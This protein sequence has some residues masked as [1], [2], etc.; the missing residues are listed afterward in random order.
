MFAGASLHKPGDAEACGESDG[1][2]EADIAVERRSMS[3]QEHLIRVQGIPSGQPVGGAGGEGQTTLLGIKLASFAAGEGR[4]SN[5][6][7]RILASH[8][9]DGRPQ[10]QLRSFGV[11][12]TF[13]CWEGEG[14]K[15]V[16]SLVT[17][18]CS[19]SL[20]PG[21]VGRGGRGCT[22]RASENMC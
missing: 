4:E 15:D 20:P 12:P 22:G 7:V 6:L 3:G 1:R 14:I 11:L 2:G 18:V 8:L 10:R 5:G 9:L 21:W 19:F 13:L 17:T 16:Y